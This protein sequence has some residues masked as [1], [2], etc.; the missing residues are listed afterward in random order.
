MIIKEEILLANGAT[1]EEYSNNDTIFSESDKPQYYFQIIYGTVELNNYHENG[2]EFTHNILRDGQSFGESLLFTDQ[3]YPMN[4]VVKGPSMILKLP[5]ESFLKLVQQNPEI[6][7][8]IVECLAE[9]L[10]YKYTML[11]NLSSSNP[12]LKIEN[13]LNYLKS[14]NSDKKDPYTFEVPLTRQQLANLT[15]LRI[16]T[17]I[18][19]VKKMEKSNILR[20]KGRTIYY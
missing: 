1:F 11:F 15:G 4:A 18:R 2:S 3:L 6:S 9:R 10:F 14:F 13:I 8:S 19:T 16:E 20:L 7:I 12:M 17:V 5:K